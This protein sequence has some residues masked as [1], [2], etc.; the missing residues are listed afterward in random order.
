MLFQA[1]SA[2]TSIV[3]ILAVAFGGETPAI[4]DQPPDYLGE[5]IVENVWV[6]PALA[7]GRSILRFRITNDSRDHIHL[8]DVQTPVA[9]AAR[10]VGRTGGSST[11]SL[12]SIS[13]LADSDLDL[14]TGHIWIELGP[15]TRAVTPGESIPLELIFVHSRVHVEAHVHSANG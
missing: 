7:G 6:T 14:T 8:L 10:I 12:E 4:A 5:I 3:F 1:R 15:L 13:V 2:L 9:K 11:T